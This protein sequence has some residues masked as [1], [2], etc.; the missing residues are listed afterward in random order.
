MPTNAFVTGMKSS[1]EMTVATMHRAVER[2]HDVA[3]GLH[4]RELDA[5]DRGDDRDAADRERVEPEALARER[6]RGRDAEQ[7]HRDGGHGVRLEQ[8]GRH[9]G[10][11]ADVVADVVRDHGRVARVVLRDPRLDLAD[12]VGADVGGLRVDAAA[13]PG[14]DGD[15]RA[16]EGEP[17]EVMDRLRRGVADP[18]GEDPVV[19]RDAE[20]AE[21]D[22]EESRDRAGAE[23]DV[24]RLRQPVPRSL[25]GPHVR[26]HGD[27]HPDEAG[28]GRQDR[29]DEKADRRRPAERV[30]E[31]EQ[32]ERHDRDDRDRLVLAAQVRGGALLHGARDL[33]HALVA[34]RL[35]Q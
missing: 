22:D 28:R 9:A 23:R 18:T 16:A 27:V 8:V 26:A 7:H 12:E 29:A 2:V 1:A 17:D 24:E 4:T 25:R 32:Q 14:E 20:Q 35:S 3:A 6:S 21:P 10:A 11:V 30:V 5:D 15:E 13:E 34:C 31:A 33:L 19:A